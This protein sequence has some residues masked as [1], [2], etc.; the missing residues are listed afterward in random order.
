MI[1]F[2][3]CNDH[4]PNDQAHMHWALSF[5]K[6]DHAAHFSDKV[7][8]SWRKGKVYYLDWDVFKEDFVE[9]FFPKD[10]QLS[11][12]TKLKGTSWYQ[13]RIWSRTTSI[14]SKSS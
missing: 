3:I 5:F 10:E 2:T 12:I 11:A 1:Y 6:T 9:H 14:A 4:F 7:L 13:V 8:C